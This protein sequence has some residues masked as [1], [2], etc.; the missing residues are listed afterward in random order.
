MTV[1]RPYDL[2]GDVTGSKA[3]QTSSHIVAHLMLGNAARKFTEV[4]GTS[5]FHSGSLIREWLTINPS[6]RTEVPLHA[7]LDMAGG[8]YAP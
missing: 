5:E 2:K 1:Y 8:A 3:K 6:R 7:I 4:G